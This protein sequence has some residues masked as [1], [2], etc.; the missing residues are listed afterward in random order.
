MCQYLIKSTMSFQTLLYSHFGK[1]SLQLRETLLLLS[2]GHMFAL[3]NP[4]QVAQSLSIPV[5]NLYRHLKGFSLY[6]WKCLFVRVGCSIALQEG[7]DTESKSDATKSRRR[8]TISVDGTNDPR[9]GKLL[10]YCFSWWSKKHN[11]SIRGRNVLA[12]TIKIGSM[13]IPLNI[14]IVSKQGRGNTDKPSYFIAMLKEILDFFDTS[15]VDLRKYP[16]TFDS[17]Y[18]SQQLLQILSDMGFDTKL[19]HGKS[20]YVMDIENENVKLSQH[21]KRIELHPARWGC[22]K[23]HYRTH[24]TSKTFGSLVL[25]F[26]LDMGKTRTMMVF[27]GLWKI[28]TIL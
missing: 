28:R 4:N 24:A 22:D 14:R 15:G 7:R 10:S 20:N 8:P 6:Q 2:M 17:W 3:F 19:V 9:Y 18:G 11:T 16:I 5:A 25:L 27:D 12:I 21:K 13:I 1:K 23:P 26:F